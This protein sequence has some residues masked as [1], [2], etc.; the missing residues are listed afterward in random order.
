MHFNNNKNN[1]GRVSREA[2]DRPGER[3][4]RGRKASDSTC[5]PAGSLRAS[6][7]PAA[8]AKTRHGARRAV[9]PQARRSHRARTAASV[10][11]WCSE[12]EGLAG[13]LGERRRGLLRVPGPA[14]S[15]LNGGREGSGAGDRA[16]DVNELERGRARS[17]HESDSVELRPPEVD[18]LGP[19]TRRACQ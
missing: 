10:P 7:P 18:W 5:D 14:V 1:Y 13:G 17:R 3:G 19:V 11:S 2:R 4:G 15:N 16:S 8:A 6:E 12:P 9:E